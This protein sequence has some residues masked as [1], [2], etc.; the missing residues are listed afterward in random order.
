[1]MLS[2]HNLIYFLF[3]TALLW[4]IAMGETDMR[5]KQ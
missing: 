1:M 3:I 5:Y 2:A 4:S